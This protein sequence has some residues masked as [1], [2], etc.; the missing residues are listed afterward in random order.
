MVAKSKFIDIPTGLR[1]KTHVWLFIDAG[2]DP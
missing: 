2:A 1:Y